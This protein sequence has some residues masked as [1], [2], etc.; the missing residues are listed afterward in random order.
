MNI[1]VIY[2]YKNIMNLWS[3]KK[4]TTFGEDLA[5]ASLDYRKTRCAHLE[6]LHKCLYDEFIKQALKRAQET[7]ELSFNTMVSAL[8]DALAAQSSPV[9]CLAK[10]GPLSPEEAREVGEFFRIRLADQG[11]QYSFNELIDSKANIHLSISWTLPPALEEK[12]EKS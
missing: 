12:P 4:T 11:V 8:L 10:V 1:T 7:S 9:P 2:T 3:S 6:E 5:K